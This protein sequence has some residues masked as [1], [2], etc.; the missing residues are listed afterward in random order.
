MTM[1]RS[2]SP[3]CAR[4]ASP[5]RSPSASPFQATS[6]HSAAYEDEDYDGE[7]YGDDDDDDYE[8][9]ELTH[10]KKVRLY[11]ADSPSPAGSPIE[12]DE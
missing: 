9:G 5:R 8:G 3:P 11:I 2:R 6:P 7:D 4:S 10:S 12:E 1:S